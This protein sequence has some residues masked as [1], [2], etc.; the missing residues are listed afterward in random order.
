LFAARVLQHLPAPGGEPGTIFKAKFYSTLGWNWPRS[1]GEIGF[2]TKTGSARPS[3][4]SEPFA[5]AY[6]RSISISP[7]ESGGILGLM[8]S[9]RTPWARGGTQGGHVRGWGSRTLSWLKKKGPDSGF[10]RVFVSIIR[11]ADDHRAEND[12][13]FAGRWCVIWAAIPRGGRSISNRTSPE[14]GDPHWVQGPAF[15]S[16]R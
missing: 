15:A 9:V 2:T 12:R 4:T 5:G 10:F 7:L 6:D 13:T 14:K 1:W 8:K 16:G 11:Q 3:P